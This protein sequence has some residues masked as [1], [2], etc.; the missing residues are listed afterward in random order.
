MSEGE[1]KVVPCMYLCLVDSEDLRRIWSGD[2]N[3]TKLA[4][5]VMK[6]PKANEVYQWT[7]EIRRRLGKGEWSFDEFVEDVAT[8]IYEWVVSVREAM[9]GEKLKYNFRYKLKCGGEVVG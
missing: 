9:F 1:T 3:L 4:D 2:V 6:H 5:R 8:K 7:L